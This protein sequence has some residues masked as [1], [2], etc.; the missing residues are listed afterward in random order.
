MALPETPAA[1]LTDMD[2]AG[3]QASALLA[4]APTRTR[5]RSELMHVAVRRLLTVPVCT[6]ARPF[7]IEA[8]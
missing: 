8:S 3:A 6:I 2:G 5:H 4:A 1:G 7:E